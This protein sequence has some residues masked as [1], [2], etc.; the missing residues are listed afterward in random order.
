MYHLNPRQK[1]Q[2]REI[3]W[4]RKKGKKRKERKERK[5]TQTRNKTKSQQLLFFSIWPCGHESNV[6]QALANSFLFFPAT[7]I[8]LLPLVLP[9][10][11]LSSSSC[12]VISLT[13]L[14]SSCLVNLLLDSSLFSFWI[15]PPPALYS[16]QC[17]SWAPFSSVHVLQIQGCYITGLP[18]LFW[19]RLLPVSMTSGRGLCVDCWLD[20]GYFH[21]TVCQ[22]TL[23]SKGSLHLNLPKAKPL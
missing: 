4:T 6:F 11:P 19:L 13:V 15:L 23:D 18:M 14:I 17:H 22:G 2:Q 1:R 12:I 21:I 8:V 20:F 5:K 10:L 9:V 16:D 7:L 3:L